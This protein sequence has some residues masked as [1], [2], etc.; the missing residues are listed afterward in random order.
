MRNFFRIYLYRSLPVLLDVNKKR[1]EIPRIKQVLI[2]CSHSPTLGTSQELISKLN[3]IS[4][5]LNQVVKAK[6]YEN[7]LHKIAYSLL[8]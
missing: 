7:N 4:Q 2:S 3:N 6:V 5:W 8:R 1:R